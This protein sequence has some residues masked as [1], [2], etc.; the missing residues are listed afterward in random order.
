M[1]RQKVKHFSDDEKRMIIQEYLEAGDYSQQSIM[2]K[3][4][5]SG[6]STLSRWIKK[7]TV[8]NQIIPRIFHARPGTSEERQTDEAVEALLQQIQ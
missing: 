5:I 1:K 2:R 7:Y 8:G 4:G 6:H 3:Y